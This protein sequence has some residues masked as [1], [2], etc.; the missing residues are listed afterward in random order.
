MDKWP[1]WSQKNSPPVPG[2]LYPNPKWKPQPQLTKS[3]VQDIPKAE[4]P[5]IQPA[6]GSE[7]PEGPTLLDQPLTNPP[8]EGKMLPIPEV[9]AP[10]LFKPSQNLIDTPLA[11]EV[12]PVH[13][14]DLGLNS[15]ELIG[16]VKPNA[17]SLPSTTSNLRGLL[18]VPA[19]EETP[20][21]EI[22]V[23]DDAVST[24]SEESSLDLSVAMAE[25]KGIRPDPVVIEGT[26]GA[27][28]TPG[29]ITKHLATMGGNSPLFVEL[30]NRYW[31]WNW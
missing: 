11:L 26:A 12:L 29:A 20:A 7:S 8:G 18:A 28:Y 9:K 25:V 2:G 16:P 15:D 13:S 19:V 30:R 21:H 27:M 5:A 10:K 23:S 31:S 17:P 3:K 14:A 1:K 6:P 22:V 24:I 4:V